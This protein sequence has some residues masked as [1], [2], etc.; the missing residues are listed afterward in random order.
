MQRAALRVSLMVDSA[1]DSPEEGARVRL[2]EDAATIGAL[3]VGG[4]LKDRI[5]ATQR[6]HNA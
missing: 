2:A 3:G 6:M 1:S 4:I 5:A